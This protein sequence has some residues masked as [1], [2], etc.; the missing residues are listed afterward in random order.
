MGG[1]ELP[2][3][4]PEFERE[5][6]SFTRTSYF[7]LDTGTM[8][9]GTSEQQLE[10]SKEENFPYADIANQANQRYNQFVSAKASITISGDFSLRAG[11]AI[12]LDVPKLESE[13]TT[14]VDPTDGGL[15]I[16]TEL[17]HFIS[18]KG[19]FTKLNLVRDSFG[20]SGNHTLNRT[21]VA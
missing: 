21:G 16:I 13:Q 10:K 19:T 14:T 9:A 18:T 8:P 6:D 1:K 4:N 11:D 7:V 5:L 2:T 20:R 3:L 17:C 15:Y 12:F